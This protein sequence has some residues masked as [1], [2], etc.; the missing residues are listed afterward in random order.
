VGAFYGFL[1]FFLHRCSHSLQ[2]CIQ[3]CAVIELSVGYHS[4]DYFGVRDVQ[5]RIAII[6][7]DI[8]GLSYE[9]IA[10]ATHASLGTVKSRIARGRE[11][12][13]RRLNG[14]LG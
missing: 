6:M 10:Q 3:G 13:K 14:V 1:C 9:E 2:H 7:R 4:E 5:Q 8:E 11:D 12:L